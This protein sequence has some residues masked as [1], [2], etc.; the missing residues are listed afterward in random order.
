MAQFYDESHRSKNNTFWLGD[1]SFTAFW[2]LTQV[3]N[4]YLYPLNRLSHLCI[5]AVNVEILIDVPQGHSMKQ[6]V[7][8]QSASVTGSF[9]MK[10]SHAILT[11]QRVIGIAD[12]LLFSCLVII[13]ETCRSVN[14]QELHKATSWRHRHTSKVSFILVLHVKM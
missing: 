14:Q 11:C 9:I 5:F 3:F 7:A 6:E 10:R 13:K 1:I 8:A 12:T 2:K 4:K